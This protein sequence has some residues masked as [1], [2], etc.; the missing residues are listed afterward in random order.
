MTEHLNCGIYVAAHGNV[1]WMK[2]LIEYCDNIG[3]DRQTLKK[4]RNQPF[5]LS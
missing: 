2:T 4:Y 3:R 1:D 5:K